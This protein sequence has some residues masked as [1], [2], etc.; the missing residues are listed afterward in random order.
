M[1]QLSARPFASFRSL[2]RGLIVGGLAVAVLLHGQP[3]A[4]EASGNVDLKLVM[5]AQ[6]TTVNKGQTVNLN[7]FA[8]HS[9]AATSGGKVEVL[10]SKQFTNLHITSATGFACSTSSTTFFNSPAWK[11]TCTKSAIAPNGQWFDAVQFSANAPL[12]S[13]NYGVIGAITPIGATET[14]DADNHAQVNI[15]VN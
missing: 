7:A 15:H 6:S 9:G 14:N 3:M 5:S 13:G 4:A 2:A 8:A 12:A 10:L 1:T 11:I